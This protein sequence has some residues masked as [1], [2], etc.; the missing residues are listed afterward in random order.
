MENTIKK[1]YA[2]AD[3]LHSL[4]GAVSPPG[5]GPLPW[6]LPS[7]GPLVATIVLLCHGPCCFKLLVK[8][9]SSRLQQFEGRLMM[10]QGIQAIPTEGG[11]GP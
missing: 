3:G 4:D 9:L 7:V 2:Q 11:P 8:F 6:S 10:A 5:S 1:T